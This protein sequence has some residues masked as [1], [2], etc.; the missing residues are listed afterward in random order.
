[1]KK[2]LMMV[3][4]TGTL[5]GHAQKVAKPET[6]A[7]VI[8]A[9]D[10]KK[11]LYVLAGP[12]M[13]GRETGTPGQKR[14]AAYIENEF[15]QLGL[16]PGNNGRYQLDYTV[17]QDSLTQAR[18]EVNGQAYQMDQDFNASVSNLAATL[19]FSEVVFV[20]PKSLDSLKRADL[21]GRLVMIVGSMPFGRNGNGSAYGELRNKGIAGVLSVMTNYPRTKPGARKGFGGI[22][23]FRRSLAP[24]VFTISEN[25]A[26]AITNNDYDQAK[27]N[28]SLIK[29]YSANV[30]TEVQKT[31]LTNQSSDVIGILPG[32]DL[33]DQYVVISAHYDHLGIRDGHIYYGADDDGSGTVS[34]LEIARAFVKA[35]AAGKGPRRSIVFLANSGEEEGLWGS[36]YF[37][38]H[39][40]IP[41]DRTTVDLNIDMVGRIDP[42]RKTGDSTNYVYVV[43]D[44]KL[45]TDLHPISEA[46]NSKYTKMELD[47]KYNDPSDPQRIYYRS[48]H[49]NFARKGVPIIFYFDG[50]HADYHK[51]TDTPDKI[52]YDLMAKR[53]Q[54]VFYTAWDMAN[55]D[56]MLRRDKAL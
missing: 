16:Q 40:T 53:D 33:K 10:L 21:T 31:T 24:Q 23:E 19:R 26:R 27:A 9:A 35:R 42:N 38:D 36:E 28:P 4:I 7:K 47:Y 39:P 50:I 34:V 54:L 46:Q 48:D 45:S 44:D 52:N 6:F 25:V 13:E 8:T 49:Y 32:T 14:A 55:R 12:E 2:T 20:G 37:T 3:L 56:E 30:L 29:T 18:L 22:S 5:Y 11:H 17:Y 43:G 41:L 1:M 51:P 15:K